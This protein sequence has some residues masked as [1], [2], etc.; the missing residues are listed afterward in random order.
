MSI[1]GYRPAASILPALNKIEVTALGKAY[2]TNVAMDFTIQQP[3][4][5]SNTL[6]DW[7]FSE[8]HSHG[9]HLNKSLKYF[10]MHTYK[11]V[12]AHTQS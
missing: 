3:E 5:W 7:R 8:S 6:P 4:S 11:G 9:Y 1:T 12:S 2:S 10:V